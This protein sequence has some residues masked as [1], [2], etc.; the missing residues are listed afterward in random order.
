MW[1]ILAGVKNIA[2]LRDLK[3]NLFA[4]CER[5]HR[6]E[7]K[8]TGNHIPIDGSMQNNGNIKNRHVRVA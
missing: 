5:A 3:F 8:I 1:L 7:T 4:P 6:D 2:L